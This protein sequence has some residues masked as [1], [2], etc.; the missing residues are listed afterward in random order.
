MCHVGIEIAERAGEFMNICKNEASM[1]CRFGV[2]SPYTMD[3]LL[4]KGTNER[5]WAHHLHN[6]PAAGHQS[7]IYGQLTRLPS[8]LTPLF[9]PLHSEI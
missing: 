9:L 4:H 3:L 6:R 2:T 8:R 7:K 1:Y 5:A